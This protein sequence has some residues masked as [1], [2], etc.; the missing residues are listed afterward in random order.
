MIS[1]L[2]F[3]LEL[4][5]AD[6]YNKID[7]YSRIN[8]QLTEMVTPFDIGIISPSH[9]DVKEHPVIPV[10]SV[11]KVNNIDNNGYLPPVAAYLIV[12]QIESN[13]VTIIQLSD[14]N[15][16]LPSPDSSE[17]PKYPPGYDKNKKVTRYNKLWRDLSSKDIRWVDGHY[18]MCAIC[19]KMVSNRID[20]KVAGTSINPKDTNLKDFRVKANSKEALFE[21]SSDSPLIP[22]LQNSILIKKVEHD[23]SNIKKIFIYGSYNLPAKL[24]NGRAYLEISL[25]IQQS[26]DNEMFLER[27]IIPVRFIQK[28]NEIIKGFFEHD[29]TELFPNNGKNSNDTIIVNAI[30]G[31]VL[32]NYV[33]IV[34]N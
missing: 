23:H 21:K 10:Y 18:S 6:I 12:T 25:I 22:A 27:I 5:D 28:E 30:A 13:Q 8:N 17:E 2:L 15:G 19:G 14:D 9:F 34:K 24:I 26:I 4:S 33:A 3:A 1:A 29:L 11:W 31:T 20:V 7:I 16:K 32:S